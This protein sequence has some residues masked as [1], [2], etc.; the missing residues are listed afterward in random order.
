MDDVRAIRA[1]R[2]VALHERFTV[3]LRDQP[4]PVREFA[5]ALAVL[6]DGAD[7]EL[8]GR[9][10]GLDDTGRTEAARV[11]RRLGLLAEGRV[12]R[13]VHPVVGDAVEEAMTPAEAESI[14]VHAALL[15]H[16]GGHPAE[17][18]ATQLLAASSTCHEDWQLDVL[19]SAA[20][21]A[22][23]RSAPDTAARYLRRALLGTSPEGPDR[24]ELLVELATV[25]R[26]VAPRVA[27]RHFAQALALFPD[28]DQRARVAGRIPPFL[29]DGCPPATLD[30]VVRTAANWAGPRNSPAPPAGTPCGWRHG[31]GTPHR[32]TRP[33]AA[34]ACAPS[35]P[36]PAWTP[37]PTA[38]WSPYCCTAP[39]R[40]KP[41]PPQRPYRSPSGCSS[42]NPPPPATRTRRCRC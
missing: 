42:T 6:G 28:A 26:D 32:A 16:L 23:R 40:P 18:A 7:E 10:A 14:R 1:A 34:P 11:L 5:A 31:C 15:L 12:P 24:A 29:L 2:P 33:T 41:S 4:M 27:L 30:T 38:S 35:A 22:R 25:E 39:P 17:R 36:T 21:A 8:A 19:R 20:G 9:L 13:F 3:V 37:R